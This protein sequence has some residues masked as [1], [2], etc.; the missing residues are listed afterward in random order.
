MRPVLPDTERAQNLTCCG[1]KALA[2]I[3]DVRQSQRQSFVWDIR[4]LLWGIMNIKL[5]NGTSVK[6]WKLEQRN[7]RGELPKPPE[8]Q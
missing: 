7:S 8:N 4:L 2:T 3:P 6:T 1:G 5:S